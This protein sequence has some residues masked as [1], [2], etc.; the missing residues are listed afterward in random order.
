MTTGVRPSQR[1]N[2][3]RIA[4]GTVP[5]VLTPD[6]SSGPAAPSPIAPRRTGL[7]ER[8]GALLAEHAGPTMK[9]LIVGGTVFLLDAA[10][11]NLLVFWN[12]ATGW[13]QG[14]LHGHPLTAK[15]LTIALASCLTYLGNRLWTFG[16]RPR[17]DTRRSVVLF[18]LVNIIAAGLQLACLGFSRYVL[19]LDS[20]LADNISGTLIGQIVS[21]SF[22][23]VTYGRWVFP[24]A[25]APASACGQSSPRADVSPR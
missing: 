21:T 18:V 1:P 13:G 24:R 8:T 10:L 6:E 15:V 25:Q 22:R 16:D 23:Y 12:P 3:D 11:Y 5:G 17:P 7:R 2:L 19:G 20:P 4:S 9:F 14:L